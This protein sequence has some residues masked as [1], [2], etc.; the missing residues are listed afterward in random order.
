VKP[1]DLIGRLGAGFPGGP[2]VRYLRELTTWGIGGPAVVAS[3][4]SVPELCDCIG[5]LSGRHVGWFVMG[6]GSNVLAPDA[7]WDGVVIRLGGAFGKVEWEP[8]ETAWT[9]RAG[10][11]AGLPSLAGAACMRGASGLAFAAGIP[12][13]VGGAVS[14]NAGA[15]G[16][17]FAGRIV[18]VSLVDPDG[19]VSVLPASGCGFGYRKSSFQG[20]SAIV[21][22]A[23]LDLPASPAAGLRAEAAGYLARRR[24]AFPLDMPN[25]GS[26]FRRPAEG[27][28]PGRLIEEAG[29]K[30]ASRGGAMVSPIHANFIVNTGGATSSDVA[31]LVGIVKA[32]V[33]ER[34]GIDLEEEIVYLGGRDGCMAGGVLDG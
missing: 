33:A 8:R 34:S 9:V 22:G 1:A 10:A 28:P 7:G 13:S 4:A 27:P 15:Y 19:R 30:G 32:A 31:V 26:V 18:E 14:M 29:L 17:C 21:T 23:V 3:P 5:T 20:G 11:G 24:A 6:R 2:C 25:A 16:S 12:G